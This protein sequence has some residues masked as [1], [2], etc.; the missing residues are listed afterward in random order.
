[1]ICENIQSKGI[2]NFFVTINYFNKNIDDYENIEKIKNEWNQ[3]IKNLSIIIQKANLG[4]VYNNFVLEINETN[5]IHTHGL[6]GIYNLTNNPNNIALNL[7]KILR[8]W[9]SNDVTVEFLEF[10]L[11]LKRVFVYLYKNYSE[12]YFSAFFN[13]NVTFQQSFASFLDFIE[14]QVDITCTGLTILI[15]DMEYICANKE[16]KIIF[17]KLMGLNG[18]NYVKKQ[19]INECIVDVIFNI[20]MYFFL[21]NNIKQ[22]N[23]FFVKKIDNYEI[24]YKIFIKKEN[25]FTL[26]DEIINFFIKYFDIYINGIDL[27]EFKKSAVISNQIEKKLEQ[28]HKVININVDIIFTLIEFKEGVYDLKNG[29]FTRKPLLKYLK[30]TYQNVGT[31]KYSTKYFKY[32]KIP[33]NWLK[34][35]MLKLNYDINNINELFFHL[36]IIFST[37]YEEIKKKRVLFILGQSNTL[38][39]TLIADLFI[40]YFGLDNIALITQSKNFPFQNFENKLIAILDEFKYYDSLH[41]EYL[42]LFENRQILIEKKFQNAISVNPLH[43]VIISNEDFINQQNNVDKQKALDNRIKKIIF[44]NKL[45]INED[46]IKEKVKN[47][48]LEI[49]VFLIKYYNEIIKNKKDFRK[50]KLK[51]AINNILLNK[52]QIEEIKYNQVH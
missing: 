4:W 36:A 34:N 23:D 41:N 40:E 27:H 45:N 33:E 44:E 22:Y 5:L 50:T 1:M 6:I 28:I 25:L 51:K 9:T 42:K 43:I 20:Y 3:E 2:I 11:N 32:I 38:K 18:L 39:T 24:S 48:N 31:I 7:K 12:E 19:N 29:K 37:N 16:K 46:N 26:W 13:C 14:F 30:N 52:I 17:D 8:S 35:V 47:E 21:L 49:V 15:H 10:F